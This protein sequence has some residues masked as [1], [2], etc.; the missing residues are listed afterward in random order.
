[1]FDNPFQRVEEVRHASQK[2][3]HFFE[4]M[5]PTASHSLTL[6]RLRAEKS[7]FQGACPWDFGIPFY[8]AAE[9]SETLPRAFCGGFTG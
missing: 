5:Q 8:F 7:K 2:C 1:M 6:A 3:K 9:G 4:G